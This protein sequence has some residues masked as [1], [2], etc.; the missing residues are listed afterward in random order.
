MSEHEFE[1]V[2]GSIGID[3]LSE[4]IENFEALVAFLKEIEREAT[5]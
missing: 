1:D 4:E 3:R 5:K 2:S